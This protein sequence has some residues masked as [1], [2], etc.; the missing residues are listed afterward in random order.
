M[1]KQLFTYVLRLADD[2]LIL[3]HRLS[4]MCSRGPILEED[5][6]LTN[7]ALDLIGRSQA[8]LDYAA[9]I[10]GQCKDADHYAYRRPENE[11]YNYL[12]T[13]Q[14]NN[15]FAWVIARQ[16]FFSAYELFFYRELAKSKDAEL[17][18]IAA[19]T[20]KEVKYHLEHA[21]DW[22]VRLGDGTEESNQ[23]LTAAVNHLYMFTGEFFEMDSVD[24]DLAKKG[25]AVEK[26]KVKAEWQKCIAQVFEEANLSIPNTSFMQSGSRAGIHTENLGHLLSEMQYLQRAYPDAK[27]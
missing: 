23:R 19:K 4:E 13:E 9:K 25:I 21:A 24:T 1:D 12:I 3:G 27:W 26:E 14:P 18:A 16:F 15:D 8:L 22:M 20:V 2:G 17:A 6:A 5:L 10:D 7:I 11:Y